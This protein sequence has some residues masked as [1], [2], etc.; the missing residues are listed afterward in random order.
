MIHSIFGLTSLMPWNMR[1]VVGAV[2]LSKLNVVIPYTAKNTFCNLPMLNIKS[3][4]QRCIKDNLRLCFQM[5]TK[6]TSSVEA[7]KNG[8]VYY[9]DKTDKRHTACRPYGQHSTATI[10]VSVYE[11]AN[12]LTKNSSHGP[13]KF[14]EDPNTVG[15]HC[16]RTAWQD[17]LHCF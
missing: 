9:L 15:S 6:N 12:R 7:Q 8:F 16:L 4:N 17:L 3:R 14:F 1:L 10:T 13:H 5:Q 11:L 2:F